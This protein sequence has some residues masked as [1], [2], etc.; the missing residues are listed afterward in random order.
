MVRLPGV[1]NSI[2]IAIV[3]RRAENDGSVSVA[4]I[5]R[6]NILVRLAERLGTRAVVP[7]FGAGAFGAGGSGIDACY[8][9]RAVR[10]AYRVIES[11][12]GLRYLSG[13]CCRRYQTVVQDYG[14][15]G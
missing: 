7:A 14:L 1:Q 13:S 5:Q 15:E 9:S 11:L 4:S 12:H 8:L 10:A 3:D 2:I 6:V